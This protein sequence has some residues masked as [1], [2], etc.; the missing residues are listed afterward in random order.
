[1]SFNKI[2][3]KLESTLYVIL[4]KNTCNLSSETNKTFSRQIYFPIT[5]FE[6]ASI[7]LIPIKN[8]PVPLFNTYMA[9][10]LLDIRNHKCFSFFPTGTT[11]SPTIFYAGT[12]NRTLEGS[13][14]QLIP[15]RLVNQIESNPQEIEDALETRTYIRQIRIQIWFTLD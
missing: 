15:S 4:L 7:L 8:P 1:M 12:R 11:H 3:Y 13:E 9:R 5:K 10:K 6:L 2:T 14:N